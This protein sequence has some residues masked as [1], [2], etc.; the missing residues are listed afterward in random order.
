M[1]LAAVTVDLPTE[2]D[3]AI[4]VNATRPGSLPAWSSV[5]VRAVEPEAGERTVPPGEVNAPPTAVA[6]ATIGAVLA[7]GISVALWRWMR[8][9][10]TS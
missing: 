6:G 1:D 8:K 7:V 2:G 9:R 4:V 5:T 10:R 3:Y